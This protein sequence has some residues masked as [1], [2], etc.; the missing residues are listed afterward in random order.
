MR[1]SVTDFSEHSADIEQNDGRILDTV[2][3]NA[4]SLQ[5][6]LD[7][8]A[9]IRDVVAAHLHPAPAVESI[10]A[11]DELSQQLRS[12]IVELEDQ[13]YD[14]EQQ[15]RDLASQVATETVRETVSDEAGDALSWEDRKQLIL[16][17]MEQDAFSADQFVS[18]LQQE[19]QELA[20]E[21]PGNL[22]DEL[23]S[24]MDQHA[25]E[26]VR[27]DE[28]I[29]ELRH[30]LDQQS[31][32]REGGLAIGAAAIAEAMDSDELVREERE[33]LQQMQTEWEE[34]FRQSEIEMSLER[35]QLSRE[36]QE[37]SNKQ[38]E[39]ELQMAQMKR[40]AKQ[41]HEHGTGGA[42]P[43][44]KWLAKLGLSEE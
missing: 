34:K 5:Q 36:R 6:L 19:R 37:L 31:S 28:E 41:A 11:D 25:Q 18:S 7:Q 23:R 40:D 22:L 4:Q 26:V 1:D 14:L 2:Q 10:V 12:R 35:A 13:V 33:R 24:E 29:R 44:R 9:E 43:A 16:Q 15:N 39:L 30:L 21:D 42:P 20:K 17:Q 38:A 27:R 3:S 8:V 32:T